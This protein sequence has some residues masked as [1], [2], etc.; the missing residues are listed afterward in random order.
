MTTAL[1]TGTPSTFFKGSPLIQCITN[2]ITCESMA[3]ALLYVNSKPIMADDIREFPELFK[4]IDGVLLNLGQFSVAREEQISQASHYAKEH[5]KPTVIDSVGVSVSPLRRKLVIELL[6]NEPEVVKGN[7]SELRHLVGLASLGRGVDGHESDQEKEALL[8][9]GKAL[10]QLQK[11][12]PKTTF[13]ATG[14]VDLIVVE[15]S[16]ILLENG[17]PELDQL[18]GTGDVVGAIIASLLAQGETIQDSTVG[19]VS[20]FN[21]CGERAKEK[22]EEPIGLESFKYHLYNELS[23]LYQRNDWWTSIKGVR[24]E[25]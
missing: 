6:K 16:L 15:G 21:R 18:T 19:A 22:C 9:L 3:N 11:K 5:G 13:L 8:E 12:Y 14:K 24:Y 1:L 25:S 20:Y 7:T 10:G 4:Q 17:V 2:E 23:T